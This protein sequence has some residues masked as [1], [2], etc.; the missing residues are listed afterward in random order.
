MILECFFR[1]IDLMRFYKSIVRDSLTVRSIGE[2]ELE[3]IKT[4][5]FTCRAFS[6]RY[7]QNKAYS[8]NFIYIV[9]MWIQFDPISCGVNELM[10]FA[11]VFCF[12]FKGMVHR[13]AVASSIIAN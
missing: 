11:C 12:C 7:T 8:N 1:A 6:F 10:K 3:C 5:K 9:S 4:A 13:R 2:C